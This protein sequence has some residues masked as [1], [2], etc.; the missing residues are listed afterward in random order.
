MNREEPK[1]WY[2]AYNFVKHDRQYWFKLA[3]FKNVLYSVSGVFVILF[4]QFGWYINWDKIDL[5]YGLSD[6]GYKTE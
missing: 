1:W 2:Q 6:D 4:A 5:A 3:N